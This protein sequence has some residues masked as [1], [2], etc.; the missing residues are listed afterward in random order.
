MINDVRCT[1][2][3]M[4]YSKINDVQL[5]LMMYSNDVQL[6]LMMY[7]YDQWCTVIINDVQ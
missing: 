5:W 6:W 2:W 3:L 4:M 7:S 1:V